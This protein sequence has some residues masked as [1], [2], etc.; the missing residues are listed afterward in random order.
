VVFCWTFIPLARTEFGADTDFRVDITSDNQIGIPPLVFCQVFIPRMPI[1]AAM[2]VSCDNVTYFGAASVAIPVSVD[3]CD[4]KDIKNL[5]LNLRY[6]PMVAEFLNKAEPARSRDGGIYPDNWSS[7][8]ATTVAPGELRLQF[9]GPQELSGFGKLFYLFFKPVFGSG[10]DKLNST[11]TVIGWPPVNMVDS[12]IQI[13]E[14]SIKPI[15]TPGCLYVS[16]DCIRPVNATDKYII[17]QNRPNPFNPTTT[18]DYY[19]PEA[20][21]VRIEVLDIL[22]RTVRVLVD[23]VKPEGNHSVQFNSTGLPSGMYYYRMDAPGY[24]KVMKMM[25][26]K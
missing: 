3:N 20:S 6:D 4:G 5:D 17:T 2:V 18:I 1:T 23:E 21:R 12:L 19:V 10:A 16:G 24:S 14:G 7:I 8:T 13:N 22:G 15:L 9:N 11:T 26:S 25:V